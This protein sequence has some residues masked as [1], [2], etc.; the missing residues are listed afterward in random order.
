[1]P[2]P[3]RGTPSLDAIVELG[4]GAD[5][6]VADEKLGRYVR[7]VGDELAHHSHNRI[8][9]GGDAE[10]QLVFGVI[11]LEGGREL[12]ICRVD[13]CENGKVRNKGGGPTGRPSPHAHFVFGSERI[14]TH[15]G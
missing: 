6:V 9:L 5:A 4:I 13:P 1:M 3:D 12:L 14:P 2:M 11:E 10:D 8:T 15:R 7:I